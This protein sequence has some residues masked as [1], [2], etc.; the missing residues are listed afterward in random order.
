MVRKL[1]QHVDR[2]A[3]YDRAPEGSN[4]VD[5]G[6]WRNF[7]VGPTMFRGHMPHYVKEAT[8]EQCQCASCLRI[9]LLIKAIAIGRQ[10]VAHQGCNCGPCTQGL[11]KF[12]SALQ[13]RALSLCEKAGGQRQ[14]PSKCVE[15]DCD[16][17]G[18]VNL[19]PRCDRYEVE[20][21]DAAGAIHLPC[22][23]H[24]PRFWHTNR[25][26]PARLSSRAT[27]DLPQLP[28]QATAAACRRRRGADVN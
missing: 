17:C 20:A 24:G 22:S 14:R 3:E 6:P 7:T 5:P 2:E 16:D 27:A 9:D 18:L 28:A 15:S 11:D 26:S 25:P 13:L 4:I 1:E 21:G 8:R 10:Q 12:S 23:L 19:A